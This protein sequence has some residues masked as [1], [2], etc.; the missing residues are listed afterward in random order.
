ML[1]LLEIDSYIY[2]VINNLPHPA[3]L[4]IL[5]LSVDLLSNS[6]AIWIIFSFVLIIFGKRKTKTLGLWG[7]LIVLIT[8]LFEGLLVKTVFVQR[9]RPFIAIPEATIYGIIPKT[10]SFPSGQA[11][12]AFAVATFYSL[13][14]KK[15]KLT[16][17]FFCLA[18]LTAIGRVYLG[19]H[20]PLDVIAGSLIG[21]AIGKKLFDFFR[22]KQATKVRVKLTETGKGRVMDSETVTD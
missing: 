8:T 21:I 9:I 20:Y 2:Q 13:I 15:E 17:L 19:A 12:N 6:G 5:F 10:F 16:L 14:L 3:W 1:K 7:L 22:K 18:F 11:A 4:N